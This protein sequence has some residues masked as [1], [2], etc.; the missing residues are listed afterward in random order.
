M[1]RRRGAILIGVLATTGAP[2]CA[3]PTS[4]QRSPTQQ[5]AMSPA[6][7]IDVTTR[8]TA[9]LAAACLAEGGSPS[10]WCSAYLIGVA[11]TLSAFGSGGH[12]S[13]ICPADYRIE[14]LTETFLTWARANVALD[15]IDMLAGVSLA[16][17]QRWPCRN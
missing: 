9:D 6:Q 8:R 5:E 1:N 2:A 13:G 7:R 12:R 3:E 16:F 11:D 17:R 4:P 10:G 14:D 15:Q